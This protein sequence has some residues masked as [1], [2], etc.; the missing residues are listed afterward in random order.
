V[1]AGTGAVMV[2]TL[3][4]G[5]FSHVGISFVFYRLRDRGNGD[6]QQLSFLNLHSNRKTDGYSCWHQWIW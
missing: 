4:K 3:S 5:A 1:F 2:N 6:F